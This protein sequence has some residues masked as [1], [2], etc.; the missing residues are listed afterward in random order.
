MI[1]TLVLAAGKGERIGGPKAL[2][3]L[4]AV[5]LAIAHARARLSAESEQVVVVVR[6]AVAEAL[7]SFSAEK[8]KGLAV[9]VSGEPD[10][11]GPAG[12]LR[13][14]VAS[15]MLG[16][17]RKILVTPVDVLPA[18]A[19]LAK[20]LLGPLGEPNVRA[21]RPRHGHPVAITREL[22]EAN[23]PPP[24]RRLG[25][26]ARTDRPS[27]IPPPPAPPLRTVLAGLG[28]TLR[29]LDLDGCASID[30]PEDAERI[31]GA[32]PRFWSPA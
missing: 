31:L 12:S 17:T 32:P 5:P 15:R 7:A 30:S 13:A 18:D 1:S 6:R 16:M 23:Y 10:E 9:L 2:L 24:T 4:D 25:R 26:A 14:V 29:T 20:A 8:P 28:G 27:S 19:S 3:M 11:D 21:V 22:L